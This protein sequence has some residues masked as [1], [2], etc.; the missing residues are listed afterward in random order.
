MPESYQPGQRKR[1]YGENHKIAE[2]RAAWVNTE[3]TKA[4][5]L[6][7]EDK[8]SGPDVVLFLPRPGRIPDVA[9]NLT[10]LTEPELTAL[11]DLFEAAFIWARPVV[12]QRDK[13]ADD[14]W[15]NG[16]DSYSRSYR[17]LPTVVYRKRPEYEHGESVRERLE[18]V[19]E[20][21]G[22]ERADLARGIRGPSFLV[23]ELD[24]AKGFPEDNSPPTD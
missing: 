21:S 24:E 8:G 14:A 10:N 17:P 4:V 16:D 6:L 12:R 13:E 20:G 15:Q 19:P 2:T 7:G 9:I 18:G 22:G 5:I 11:S 23:A 3:A 1:Q